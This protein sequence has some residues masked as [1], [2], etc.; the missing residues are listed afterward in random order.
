MKLSA[1]ESVKFKKLKLR[2]Q[3]SQWQAVGLLESIWMFAARNAPIGNIGKHSNEDIAV[4]IEWAGNPDDLV[5]ALV[6]CRWLD[7]DET[8]RLIIHDWADHL[9]N[10]LQAN[11]KR[12]GKEVAVAEPTKQPTVQVTKQPTVQPAPQSTM[13]PTVQATIPSS[14][15]HPSQVYPLPDEQ[16]GEL[17]DVSKLTPEQLETMEGF[18]ASVSTRPTMLAGE[19]R[20]FKT[21]YDIY[22]VKANRGKAWQAYQM[23]VAVMIRDA[24]DE[25][26]FLTIP[27]AHQALLDAARKYA[28]SPVG[29]V[30]PPPGAPKDYRLTAQG[31]LEGKAWSDPPERLL[32]GGNLS[33]SNKP[34]PNPDQKKPESKLDEYLRKMREQT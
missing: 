3:L 10:W 16:P 19:S 18:L 8:H 13:Q 30:P 22:P 5:S 17:G 29:L 25:G 28:E 4:Q 26:R 34:P 27:D 11:L 31:W 32:F 7:V 12:H 2:L 33:A 1:I 9:P 20:E 15:V 6:D 23:A 24:I 14:Q 21:W